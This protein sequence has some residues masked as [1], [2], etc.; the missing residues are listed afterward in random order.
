VHKLAQSV[1]TY[2]RKN[3]LLRPGDR[4][5]IAV[6]GGADSVALLRL[7]LELRDELGIVPTVVHLNHQLRGAES[8]ADEQFVRELAKTHE[9]EV[10]IGC[11]D[12]KALAAEKK[13]TLE[14]AAREVRYEFF[15]SALLNKLNRIATAHTLD[16]QAETV[17]LKFMRGAG[18][19]GLAGIYPRLA[20]SASAQGSAI[21]RPLLKTRRSALRSYLA[22]IG[23]SWRE[24]ATN[25]DFRYMRNRIRHE[26]LPLLESGVNPSLCEVLAENAE[27]A[28]AEEE[29][30]DKETARLLPQVWT[31]DE[32]AG[33]LKLNLFEPLALAVRRRLVRASAESLHLAL[34]FRH[35]EE[36]LNLRSEGSASVLPGEWTVTRHADQLRFAKAG[37]PT[38]DYEYELVIPGKVFVIEAGV[39]VEACVIKGSSETDKYAF[40]HLVDPRVACQKW[41]VR[42]WRAGERFWPAHTKEPKKIKEL[43]QDRHITGDEKQRWPVIACGGEIIWVRGLGVRRDFQ[44]SG[45]EGVLIRELSASPN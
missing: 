25:R 19:R 15:R 42:N 13:L 35:V 26:L 36:I 34:E 9:L 22:E 16:D 11:R 8:D 41:V 23:Q 6:S 24:D 2:I 28:R 44:A 1:L 37:L 12:V 18:T 4:V 20:V 7:M 38:S 5:G 21:L 17:L 29:Y 14:A 3:D 10:I 40:Q 32:Q 27:I 39:E 43:L 33:I 30:W 31:Q 45:A